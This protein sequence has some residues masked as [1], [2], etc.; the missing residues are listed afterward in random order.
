METKISNILKMCDIESV[1]VHVTPTV[2]MSDNAV[3][4]PCITGIKI[5]KNN[6]ST[7]YHNLVARARLVRLL[8]SPENLIAY[9]NALFT[10]VIYNY[11][12]DLID[13]DTTAIS[14]K[15]RAVDVEKETSQQ[16]HHVVDVT[17]DDAVYTLDTTCDIVSTIIDNKVVNYDAAS[18]EISRMLEIKACLIL[19]SEFD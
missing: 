8:N 1:N 15:V 12:G 13:P 2:L 3:L 9:L 14:F 19:L 5:T 6:K 11:V 10:N 16:T 17:A 7:V 18:R 4:V